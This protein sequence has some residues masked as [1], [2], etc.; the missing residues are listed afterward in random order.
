[1]TAA[2]VFFGGTADGLT[3]DQIR[4]KLQTAHPGMPDHLLDQLAHDRDLHD[5]VANA[6]NATQHGRWDDAI[7]L[8]WDLVKHEYN[9]AESYQCLGLCA[10]GQ[11]RVEDAIALYEKAIAIDPNLISARDN[12]IMQNDVYVGCTDAHAQQL[13]ADWWRTFG[14]PLYAQ[15]KPHTNTADP[16]KQ[17]RIAYV[18]GDFRFHSA[19][20]GFTSLIMG[21]DPKKYFPICYSTLPLMLYDDT[22]RYYHQRLGPAFVDVSRYSAGTLAQVMIDDGIDIAIDLSGHTA[23]NRLQAFAF[24]PAPIQLN[25]WGYAIDSGLPCMDGLLADPYVVPP[26]TR[27]SRHGGRVIDLPSILTLTARENMPPVSKLPSLQSGRPT[28][29]VFQ[30]SMKV[31]RET[32]RIWARILARVPEA[33]MLFK[34]AGS[35]PTWQDWVV[36]EMA[37]VRGQLM[38]QMPTDH[39]THLLWHDSI[40]VALDTWPQTGGCSSLEGLWM[41]VPVVTLT[42]PRVIQRTTA[43]FLH[44]LGLDAFIAE[45]EDEYVEISVQMVRAE[46]RQDLATIRKGLR[47]AISHSP[48][49]NGYPQAVEAIYRR[50]WTEYCATVNQADAPVN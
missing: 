47:T 39:K 15:R 49:I 48:I 37:S 2:D 5:Q 13:R 31:N 9:L 25:G 41:G 26:E 24:K 27:G 29:G 50:L 17:L 42:G 8:L 36:R 46:H 38:F 33:M 12:H 3:P 10:M 11:S 16:D 4:R 7:P 19:A 6:Y 22:T 43:S 21:H 32:C 28:F 30:R 18:S 14:A 23:L 1:M 20:I 45:T 34:C 44:T 35:S 40:D